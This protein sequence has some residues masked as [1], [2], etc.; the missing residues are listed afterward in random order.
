MEQDKICSG[1]N[2]PSGSGFSGALQ[3]YV[4]KDLLKCQCKGVL[5]EN[6]KWWCKKHAPSKIE[7]R[8]KKAWNNYIKRL[9]RNNN[10]D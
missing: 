5:F 10:K 6:N 1:K 3:S 8:E 4:L 9:N 2:K 7:E